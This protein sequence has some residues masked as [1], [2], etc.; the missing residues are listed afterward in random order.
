MAVSVPRK[1]GCAVVRNRIRRIT[2]EAFRLYFLKSCD[3]IIRVDTDKADFALLKEEAEHLNR[4]IDD[5][6][7]NPHTS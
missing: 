5:K 7:N 1:V 2:R 3:L 6:N 4:H